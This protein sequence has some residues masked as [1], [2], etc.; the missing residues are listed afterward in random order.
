MEEKDIPAEEKDLRSKTTNGLY[1]YSHDPNT[2][3]RVNVINVPRPRPIVT[4]SSSHGG[5]RSSGSSRS[6]SCF[7]SSCACACAGAC[8]GGGR[9]GCTT[10]DFYNTDL[11]LRQLEL[12]KK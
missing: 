2:Y 4:H 8:A 5:A 11:K 7:H 3:I 12:K 10:K 6:S 1:R 9:A